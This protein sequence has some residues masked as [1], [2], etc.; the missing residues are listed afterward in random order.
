[1][2]TVAHTMPPPVRGRRRIGWLVVAILVQVAFVFALVEGLNI[3]VIHDRIVDPFVVSIPRVKPPPQPA[4]AG[5]LVEPTKANPVEPKIIFDTGETGGTAINPN[6]GTHDQPLPGDRSPLGI[7]TT[8]T[9]PPYPPLALRLGWEGTVTLRLAIAPQGVVTEAVVVRS[10]GYPI[11]DEAARAWVLA[12]WRYQGAIRGG[13]AAPGTAT[14]GVVFDLKR[15][16]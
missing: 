16:G 6:A 3:K 12:H 13:A 1:M 14:V 5:T 4:P 9:T 7:V 11:L 2:Q 8:H 15:P 10:S